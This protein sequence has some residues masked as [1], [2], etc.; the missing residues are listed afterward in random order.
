MSDSA[1]A[2]ADH[3]HRTCRQA[4]LGELRSAARARGLRLTPARVRVLEILGESHRAMGAYEILDRLRAEGLGRQPPA[5]YRALE[6]LIAHGFVHRIEKLNAYVAC[7]TPGDE[8]GSCFLIC[9]R[10]R[11]VAEIEDSA[12][13]LAVAGAAAARGFAMDRAVMEIDGTCPACRAR[14]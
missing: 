10:C 3:D 11:Q 2:F 1:L 5:V 12:L 9:R 7:C 4:A 6:F 14:A 13:E 8:H